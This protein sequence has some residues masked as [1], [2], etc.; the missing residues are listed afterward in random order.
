MADASADKG[1]NDAKPG[2][3]DA[4]AAAKAKK[5]AAAKAKA[6]AAAE[7]TEP[8]KPSVAIMEPWQWRSP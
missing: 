3:G 1:G 6:E 5:E 7:E 8:A 2:K 4:A